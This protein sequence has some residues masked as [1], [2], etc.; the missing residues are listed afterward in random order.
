MLYGSPGPPAG[1][2]FSGPAATPH[3]PLLVLGPPF[4]PPGR[5]FFRPSDRPACGAILG[6][7]ARGWATTGM[8]GLTAHWPAKGSRGGRGPGRPTTALAGPTGPG[9]ATTALWA[10]VG[11][12]RGATSA[13]YSDLDFRPIPLTGPA[14]V[15]EVPLRHPAQIGGM[16]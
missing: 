6:P 8:A 4:R 16:R 2:V 15:P 3:L 14:V 7:T 13:L 11:V 12:A 1:R 9:R 10:E 5:I